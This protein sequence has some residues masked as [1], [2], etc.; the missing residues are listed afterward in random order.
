MARRLGRDLKVGDCIDG[1]R[2]KAIRSY[3]VPAA[4]LHDYY[5]TKFPDGM[6]GAIVDFDIGSGGMTIFMD[7]EY[8]EGR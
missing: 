3:R 5:A 6:P 8:E 4:V 1:K 7:E 2:I